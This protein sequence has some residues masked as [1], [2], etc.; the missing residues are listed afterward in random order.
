MKPPNPVTT[1]EALSGQ[2]FESARRTITAAD[3]TNFCGISGDFAAPHIDAHT[4]A[5]TEYGGIIAPGLLVVS[6]AT[7]LADAARP[8]VAH[9]S[10]GYEKMRF[11]RG[12]RP[13]T[14]IRVRQTVEDFRPAKISENILMDIRYEVLD[15]DDSLV[16]T[17][18]HILYAPRPSEEQMK[19]EP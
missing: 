8:I 16:A 15:Q 5:L 9:S 2:P 11:L 17:W 10:Y 18:I 14:T 4:M 3:I 13:G 6:V 12:V 19:R 1:E 7:G